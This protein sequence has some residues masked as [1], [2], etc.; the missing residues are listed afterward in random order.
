L[1]LES[2]DMTKPSEAPILA[3]VPPPVALPTPIETPPPVPKTLAEQKSDFTAE[4]SPPPGKVSTGIPAAEP[5]SENGA[6]HKT[7][8]PKSHNSRK[9]EKD[10]DPVG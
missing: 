9:S 2:A 6:D 8:E 5:V 4:G 3:P 7:P 10:V 1:Y